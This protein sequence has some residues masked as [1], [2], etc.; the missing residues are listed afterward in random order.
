MKK[1]PVLL[2]LIWFCSCEDSNLCTET[3]K[4][5][6]DYDLIGKS[7][8]DTVKSLFSTNNLS[9]DNF[10]VYCLQKDD[11]GHRHVRCQ[12]YAN[13]LQVFSDEVIFHFNSQNQ[14]YFLSGEIIP[15]IDI[16]SDPR[17]S[18]IEVMKLFFDIV[19][20]DGHFSSDNFKNDCLQCEIGYYDLNAGTGNSTHNF[21][22]AWRIQRE[23]YDFPYAYINDTEKS[24]IYYDNGIRY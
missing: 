1:I 13:N 4:G 15:G 8:Y 23:D 24:K 16:S 21:K 17:M 11:L 9:L 7:D 6:P 10:W 2:I 14:Y 20:E 22:L 3:I 19:D 5:K 12:Q 18:K